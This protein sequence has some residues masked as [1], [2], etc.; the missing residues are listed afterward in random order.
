MERGVPGAVGLSPFF[1]FPP[2][3]EGSRYRTEKVK[4]GEAGDTGCD[5]DGEGGIRL[6]VFGGL[7]ISLLSMVVGMGRGRPVS[8]KVKALREQLG[9]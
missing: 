2:G 4:G 5:R 1:F 7:V 6:S 9:F 8:P 3:G